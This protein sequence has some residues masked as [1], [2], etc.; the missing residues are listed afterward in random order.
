M[1]PQLSA[2]NLA[3]GHGHAIPSPL[4]EGIELWKDAL[5]QTSCGPLPGRLPPPSPVIL[6]ETDNSL[7]G[8]PWRRCSVGGIQVCSHVKGAG[9]S[10][11]PRTLSPAANEMEDRIVFPLRGLLQQDDFLPM[12]PQ[13]SSLPTMASTTAESE[14]SSPTCVCRTRR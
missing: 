4:W 9:V 3:T 12:E 6:R 1:L 5:M 7:L 13:A 8:T 2:S 10:P 14:K 11:F